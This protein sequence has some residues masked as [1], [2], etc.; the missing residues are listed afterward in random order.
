MCSV[1]L[2]R[3]QFNAVVTKLK[4][5]YAFLVLRGDISVSIIFAAVWELNW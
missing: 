1:K 2:I 4:S 5:L 3:V